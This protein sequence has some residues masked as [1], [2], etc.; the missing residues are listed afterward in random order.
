M[1]L[2]FVLFSF[3]LCLGMNSEVSY[4]QFGH[5]QPEADIAQTHLD[6]PAASLGERY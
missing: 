5:W 6:T 2:N 3:A 4:G 1:R